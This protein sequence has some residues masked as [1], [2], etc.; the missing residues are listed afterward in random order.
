MEG[1]ETKETQEE[2]I[3]KLPKQILEFADFYANLAGMERDTLLTRLVIERLKEIKA[4]V[5]E[6]PHLD[7][8]ELY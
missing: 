6:L 2:A 1:K 7:I 3:L 5:K 4:Q 8:P